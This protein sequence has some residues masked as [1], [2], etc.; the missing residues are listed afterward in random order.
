MGVNQYIGARYVPL[1]K[2]EWDST[3]AYDPL[4]VVLYQ[5]NSY[6]SICYVPAGVIPTDKQFWTLS[7]N[8]NAQV[9][10]Y[11][12]EVKT[13]KERTLDYT[14]VVEFGVDNTGS[15]D[16]TT[17]LQ[18]L[19]DRPDVTVLYLPAGTYKIAGTLSITK[20]FICE[21]IISY[22]GNTVCL[23]VGKDEQL[24]DI[25][26]I[27]C[28]NKGTAIQIRPTAGCH[29]M[30]LNVNIITG[31]GIGISME[32]TTPQ[33]FMQYCYIHF[34]LIIADVGIQGSVTG[35][36]I[37]NNFFYGGMLQG[38]TG[39]LF[40]PI[41]GEKTYNA[42]MWYNIGFEQL[43]TYL[44]LNNCEYNSFLNVRMIESENVGTPQYR[45]ILNNCRGMY[46]DTPVDFEYKKLQCTGSG[47]VILNG[48]LIDE[49]ITRFAHTLYISPSLISLREP[50]TKTVP[51]LGLGDG[52]NVVLGNSYDLTYIRAEVTS[53]TATISIE[54]DFAGNYWGAS[55]TASKGYAY[56]TLLK[57]GAGVL[58]INF[59]G[60]HTTITKNGLYI[61]VYFRNQIRSYAVSDINFGMLP[62]IN[63]LDNEIKKELKGQTSNGGTNYNT[64]STPD[65]LPGV[66]FTVPNG[67]AGAVVYQ[68]FI[69]SDNIYVRNYTKSTGAITPFN[70]LINPA[71]IV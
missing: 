17:L 70:K 57:E 7:G 27:T 12:Q 71:Q 8:Y 36:W 16:C 2:G 42:N 18:T 22:T 10:A 30:N 54:S 60:A 14:N 50:Y 67:E 11:R 41:T 24:I 6:T 15:V 64:V 40:N 45:V 13:L 26:R 21:G 62:Y 55:I 1:I 53:G 63:N 52:N 31:A 47:N 33:T 65:T 59:D 34:S 48:S 58:N 29:G 68:Y 25:N 46:I 61:I 3:I 23:T 4:T 20:T 5:G 69:G 32:M 39:I 66:V 28:N 43:T 35:G 49:N 38:G 44:N 9:E 37:N 19:H 56:S 51:F